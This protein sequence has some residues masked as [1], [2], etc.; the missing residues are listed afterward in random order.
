MVTAAMTKQRLV[1]LRED[2]ANICF[3]RHLNVDPFR[4]EARRHNMGVICGNSPNIHIILV[5]LESPE[6]LCPTP[7]S[8]TT[9]REE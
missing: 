3:E 2:D 5:L 6:T 1:E 7:S 8:N 9:Q 4:S